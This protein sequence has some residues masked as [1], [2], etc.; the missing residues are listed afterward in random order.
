MYGPQFRLRSFDVLDAPSREAVLRLM[1][2]ALIVANVA[3]LRRH[4][5]T[6]PLY[7]SGVRYEEEPGN[8]DDWN[9]IPETLS[10]GVG[11]CEDLAG[12]RIAELRVAGELA[13]MPRVSVRTEGTRI[14]YH[15]AVRRAA[16][17]IEDPS[18]E[19]RMPRG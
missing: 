9:D 6:P 2:E 12:W 1:M 15:I 18:R 17:A 11:D 7:E 14:T 10:L 19:L 4:P 16:G 5:G 3:Y 8:Q 13:A